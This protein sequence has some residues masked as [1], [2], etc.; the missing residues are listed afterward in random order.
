MNYRIFGRLGWNVSEIGYG[1]WGLAGG[2][3]GWQGGKEDEA[4]ESLLESVR[5]GINFFDTA[6][7]YGRGNGEK[8][9]TILKEAYPQKKLY[10]ATKVPPKNLQWPSKR[11]DSIDTIFPKDH[12]YEYVEKSLKNLG[13]DKIDLL[14]F[15][16][17][18]DDWWKED[19]WKECICS[20]KEQNLIEGVGISVNTWEPW[21]IL[22]TLET[23][24]IDTVQM[25]YN[26]FEQRP[27]DQLIPYCREKNIG[28]IARVPFDEGSLTGNINLDTKFDSNDWRASYF[29][30]ENLEQCVPRVDMIRELLTQSQSLSELA[31]RFILH[32][33]DI[34]TVIPGMRSLKHLRSNVDLSD[35]KRLPEKTMQRLRDF[36]WDREPTEWSQ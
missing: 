9:L 31:L 11:G 23:G 16:V 36:R 27:E 14:Q 20:L 29:V 18:E 24:L 6:W 25:I 3:G 22:R 7:I 13:T 10:I 15:H 30:K 1:T 26:I 33:Q 8:K 17:W 34:S 4:I 21:N 35:N 5:L 28:L 2:P 32:N 12:I 19:N